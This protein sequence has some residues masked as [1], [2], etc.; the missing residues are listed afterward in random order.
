MIH[1][2]RG[3]VGEAQLV[4]LKLMAG[5]PSLEILG[6]NGDAEKNMAPMHVL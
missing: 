3:S 2:Q 4:R 6:A 5:N 1:D